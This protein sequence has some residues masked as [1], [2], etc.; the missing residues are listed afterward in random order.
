MAVGLETSGE[1]HIPEWKEFP[2]VLKAY[3]T[4]VQGALSKEVF[5]LCTDGCE[6]FRKGSDR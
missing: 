6:G 5:L 1:I 4:M 3:G 2:N